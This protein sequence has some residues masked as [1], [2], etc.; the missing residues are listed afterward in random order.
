MWAWRVRKLIADLK[1]TMPYKGTWNGRY[2]VRQQPDID[3]RKCA[4]RKLGEARI[5]AA[6]QPLIEAL[7]D[8]HLVTEAAM[9]LAQIGDPRAIDPLYNRLKRIQSGVQPAGTKW[10]SSDTGP[11]TAQAL[12]VFALQHAEAL[13]L[14]LSL[15]TD[16]KR[17]VSEVTAKTL[18]T[19]EQS[20]QWQPRDLKERVRFLVASAYAGCQGQADKLTALGESAIEPLSELVRQLAD[21]YT[22]QN[23]KDESLSYAESAM[24]HLAKIHSRR[25]VETLIGFLPHSSGAVRHFAVEGLGA[26]NDPRAIPH[27]APLTKDFTYDHFHGARKSIADT[28]RQVLVSMGAPARETIKALTNDP[29]SGVREWAQS[30]LAKM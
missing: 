25:N 16:K 20:G 24:K 2:E 26:I 5:S 7:E 21:Q 10:E 15:L 28:A 17:S 19:M 9:A 30:A 23:Q 4:V 8:A 29:H 22:G 18:F 27:L 14:L 11:A 12:S 1:A 3:K 13:D 6:V